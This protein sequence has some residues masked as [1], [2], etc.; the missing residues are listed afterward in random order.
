MAFPFFLSLSL[1]AL[2]AHVC[3]VQAALYSDYILA[4]TS[5][6][7]RPASV[8]TVNGTVTGTSSLT[9]TSGSAVFHGV[10]GV[11]YDFGKNVEGIVSFNVA[12]LS[13]IDQFVG[14]TFSESSLWISGAHSDATADAGFD[15]VLW[16]AAN[17]AGFYSA[18]PEH[19][20]GAFRY[21]SVV[22]NATGSLTLSNL[23]IHFTAFPNAADNALGEY[24]GYFHCNDDKLNRVWY[25]G[26]YT[27]QLCTIDPNAGNSLVHLG[28]ITS[29]TVVNTTDTWYN[30][31]TISS[32]TSV[33]VDGAKRDR[34][35]WPG[36]YVIALP[37]TFVSTNDISAIKNGLNSLFALQ[38]STG[39][40]P[41][42]GIPFYPI[43]QGIL[44]DSIFSFT[45][46]LHNIISAYYY[47]LYSGD[48]AYLKQLWPQI[49][50]GLEFSL[51]HVDSTGLQYVTTSPDWLRFGMG[52]HN[53]EV[54]NLPVHFSLLVDI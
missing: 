23:T 53:I 11:T 50:L 13:G 9:T 18:S 19:R 30:N 48:L 5:R 33:L 49:K 42:S 37:S 39:A 51:S 31:Y 45:Y 12:T 14:V 38:N 32:G 41:Y 2:I 29:S 25:A 20:R 35:V 16:F 34:L 21:L 8:R 17:A 40:L 47:Y 54:M 10:A 44:G 15:E 28:V 3:T 6:T 27:D 26:A 52:G 43:L 22:T 36:D 7:L 46:H 1:S 4:P 24:S